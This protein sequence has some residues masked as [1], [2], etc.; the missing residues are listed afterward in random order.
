M[1]DT[2]NTLRESLVEALNTIEPEQAAI[3]T[4]VETK[5]ER[6]RDDDGKFAKKEVEID[7]TAIDE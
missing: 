2:Q 7:K 6:V 1:D 4:P 3:E 5:I